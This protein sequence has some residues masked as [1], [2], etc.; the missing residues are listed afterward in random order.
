MPPATPGRIRAG[1]AYVRIS[2]DNSA[3]IRGLENAKQS[4]R[5][6]GQSLKGVGADMMQVAGVISLPLA[7]SAKEFADFDDKMRILRAI[8]GATN[9][10]AQVLSANIRNLGAN[11]AFTAA[12]VGQAAVELARM[13]FNAQEVQD[14]LRPILDLTRATGTDTFKLGEVASYASAALRGFGLSSQKFAEV[15]DIMGVAADNSAMDIADLGEALKIAAPSAK[16]INEDI[17]DTASALMLMANAGVRGSLAGTS[18]RKVYQSLAAQ[19]G[20]VKGLSQE[21]LEQGIR[22]AEELQRMGIKLVDS[23]GNLRKT[24]VIMA[25]IAKKSRALKNGE[26]I[27]FATDIFDLRGSLGALSIM[28]KY[29]L[30]DTYRNMLDNA[31]G[32]N[33]EIADEIE[34]GM[35][36]MIR[37]VISQL[38]ELQI[39]IGDALD[40]TFGSVRKKIIQFTNSLRTMIVVNQEFVAKLVVTIGQTF[41]LG[42]ALFGL[43]AVIKILAAGIGAVSTAITVADLL[44][45]GWIRALVLLAKTIKAV[46][47]AMVAWAAVHPVLAAIAGSIWFQVGAVLALLAAWKAFPAVM[48]TVKNVFASFANYF[49]PSLIE[50]KENFVDAFR[51]IKDSLVAGDFQGAVKVMMAALKLE[52]AMGLKPIKELWI[53]FKT[54]LHKVWLDFLFGTR[55][56]WTEFSYGFKNDWLKFTNGLSEA[57]NAVWNGMKLAF[58]RFSWEFSTFWNDIVAHFKKAFIELK[59]LNP[60]SDMTAADVEAEKNA[61]DAETKAKN[62]AAF[63]RYNATKG[64][65][66]SENKALK[67]RHEA[68]EKALIAEYNA[69]LKSILDER[70]NRFAELENAQAQEAAALYDEIRELQ[71][72]YNNAKAYANSFIEMRAKAKELEKYFEKIVHTFKLDANM[73]KIV[74]RYKRALESG[75]DKTKDQAEADLLKAIERERNLARK[76]SDQFYAKLEDAQSDRVISKEEDAELRALAKERAKHLKMQE[77]LEGLMRTGMESTEAAIADEK[78]RSGIGA[79]S[80]EAINAM[81]NN[82]DAKRTADAT[83][84]SA[85]TLTI[86]ERHLKNRTIA[87]VYGA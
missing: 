57:W 60:F 53:A 3:L 5:N 85:K 43:G 44:V 18:L 39:A 29:A 11:T 49:K 50:I 28:D 83:E 14:G 56:A 4:I 27:N 82:T 33:K 10:E 73:Q 40:K 75:D 68:A 72:A 61:I 87:T 64:E 54:G 51:S 70:A 35:G 67:A 62:N 31:N 58:N 48:Q 8:T 12:Q 76:R 37:Q 45:F 24:N 22:G 1:E 25:E 66:E 63:T 13:G 69:K 74:E 84:S 55:F 86:I 46:Q 42:A 38:K 77:A 65:I 7:F 71:I 17:R 15:C 23:N 6:F 52:F 21:D 20:K 34:A 78:K 16:T 2:T 19:S 80:S 81:L 9:T 32:K 26:K 79:W 30:L 36:G 47:A 59:A 41:A